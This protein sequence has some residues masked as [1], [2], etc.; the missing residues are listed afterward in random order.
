MYNLFL[1]KLWFFVIKKDRK[2]LINVKNLK[3]KCF[4]GQFKIKNLQMKI[5]AFDIPKINV[6]YKLH[7]LYIV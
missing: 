1:S 4:F 2:F 5:F 6:M 7:I 3:E